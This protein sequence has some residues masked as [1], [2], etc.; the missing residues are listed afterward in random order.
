MD[1][2]VAVN[3]VLFA[4]TYQ[5]FLCDIKQ[6]CRLLPVATPLVCFEDLVTL[7]LRITQTQI[8][9]GAIKI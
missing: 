1:F 9:S 7:S 3:S 4:K 8:N 6:L 2:T 5:R